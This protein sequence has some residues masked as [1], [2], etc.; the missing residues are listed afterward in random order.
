MG[1]ASSTLIRNKANPALVWPCYIGIFAPMAIYAA[2]DVIDS[3]WRRRKPS[4]RWFAIYL[5]SNVVYITAYV[6]Y[7][8][9]QLKEDTTVDPPALR[10]HTEAGTATVAFLV[11]LLTVRKIVRGFMVFNMLSVVA[12]RFGLVRPD[13][14]S[15][16]TLR[17]G[18]CCAAQQ[19]VHVPA[20]RWRYEHIGRLVEKNSSVLMDDDFP[21]DSARLA[22]LRLVGS[23]AV[24]G[25]SRSRACRVC[26]WLWQACCPAVRPRAHRGVC[27]RLWAPLLCIWDC[28]GCFCC[29]CFCCRSWSSRRRAP[30]HLQRPERSFQDTN[31]LQ[32]D[33]DL[34]IMT[35]VWLWRILS[36]VPVPFP[37][38]DHLWPLTDALDR[39]TLLAYLHVRG[40]RLEELDTRYGCSDVGAFGLR[41]G[42][43][44]DPAAFRLSSGFEDGTAC[45][46]EIHG[47]YAHTLKAVN[48]A[49]VLCLA[50]RQLQSRTVNCS[51]KFVDGREP[52]GVD[53][54][55][56]LHDAAF[57]E[58]P[59]VAAFRRSAATNLLVRFM[60]SAVKRAFRVRSCAGAASVYVSKQPSPAELTAAVLEDANAPFEEVDP[61]ERS[62]ISRMH[63]GVH[64]PLLSSWQ[65]WHLQMMQQA[66]ALPLSE[67][68]LKTDVIAAADYFRTVQPAG[69]LQP[70]PT[71][72][73][74]HPPL[75]TAWSTSTISCIVAAATATKPEQN[76]K[77]AKM[78]ALQFHHVV[79]TARLALT[80]ITDLHR[81]LLR[82]SLPH[83]MLDAVLEAG[84]A[85]TGHLLA[86]VVATSVRN[87]GA[88]PVT[89]A[90]IHAVN[91]ASSHVVEMQRPGPGVINR[92]GRAAGPHSAP[93]P[94][95]G[96]GDNLKYSSCVDHE[97][98]VEGGAKQRAEEVAE[99]A[100]PLPLVQACAALV[101]VSG[102]FVMYAHRRHSL[103]AEI[104]DGQ[105]KGLEEGGSWDAWLASQPEDRLTPAGRAAVRSLLAFFR[106]VPQR[107]LE[108]CAVFYPDDHEANRDGQ[109]DADR[110]FQR[111]LERAELAEHDLE[112]ISVMMAATFA[113]VVSNGHAFSNGTTELLATSPTLAN[114]PSSPAGGPPTSAQPPSA[115]ACPAST[116]VQRHNGL[117]LSALH[118]AVC[119]AWE[120]IMWRLK[121]DPRV[122]WSPQ[123][124][125][126]T[127]P[128]AAV[129][130][131]GVL[132]PVAAHAAVESARALA[133]ARS[134][135]VRLNQMAPVPAAALL[136]AH[137]QPGSREAGEDS[138]SDSESG[139]FCIVP[140]DAASGPTAVG[141]PADVIA[142]SATSAFQA[143]GSHLPARLSLSRSTHSS[144]STPNRSR[145]PFE[146]FFD[147]ANRV[148][149]FGPGAAA[150]T[151]PPPHS[152]A[153]AAHAAAGTVARSAFDYAVPSADV[154]VAFG[155]LS[156]EFIDGLMRTADTARRAAA[157]VAR[158]AQAVEVAIGAIHRAQQAAAVQEWRV[159]GGPAAVAD[160]GKHGAAEPRAQ[161]D[162]LADAAHAAL[163]LLQIAMFHV[164]LAEAGSPNPGAW[165]VGD[166]AEEHMRA[167]AARQWRLLR[168]AYA[169]WKER[170]R[171]QPPEPLARAE[172]LAE[173]AMLSVDAAGQR[174]PGMHGQP[175]PPRCREECLQHVHGV[176]QQLHMLWVELADTEPGFTSEA[177]R[178]VFVLWRELRAAL[179]ATAHPLLEHQPHVPAP[180]TVVAAWAQGA[181]AAS[182]W[183]E[184][185]GEDACMG[186][187]TRDRRR[188]AFDRCIFAGWLATE[189]HARAALHSEPKALTAGAH[190]HRVEVQ[191]SNDV[192][193]ASAAEEQEA[194]ADAAR[195]Y[196]AEL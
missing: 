151:H 101:A 41:P 29:G 1:S 19:R 3:R 79:G 21:G 108:S 187:K 100:L 42:E 130:T 20:A 166:V 164:V 7:V 120:Y 44:Y 153:H 132:R 84:S 62:M 11:N 2:H 37:E 143:F 69:P 180:E 53:R 128:A 147:E 6:V 10:N 126:E 172:R 133:A 118:H 116:S 99:E 32:D 135:W 8:Y 72:T 105:D 152:T 193:L 55:E 66:G 68:K 73:A 150:A 162:T 174:M 140:G 14:S 95:H 71:A 106:T 111:F 77:I 50:P 49:L 129:R 196:F 190:A 30:A 127:L 90:N 175:M 161:M 13:R 192:R 15:C 83:S 131:W 149:L 121:R 183:A 145:K 114:A 159:P 123:H 63:D 144:A 38:C 52:N 146:A 182:A 185:C 57:R 89:E 12:Q 134:A 26:H 51:S 58:G 98:G 113:A 171:Q 88:G 125:A 170:K 70:L 34:T 124:V 94:M 31:V 141:A 117:V 40:H 109:S 45:F 87:A 75:I 5:I 4:M 179:G 191:G 82:A 74:R 36:Q 173:A 178:H 169:A 39:A 78:P 136:Q 194:A 80:G 138:T 177:G 110:S 16:C 35:T 24:R 97:G 184:A 56:L 96:P 86:P 181:V 85:D 137:T 47:A 122:L 107:M 54:L 25:V 65:V 17:C 27:C 46:D 18:C 195:A 188:D 119:T 102:S 64:V 23:M 60:C 112:G 43:D 92:C 48:A 168:G 163:A 176:L 81:Q 104:A 61:A 22:W 59:I 33:T 28:C 186:H 160:S 9:A 76:E 103:R 167:F 148:F 165:S 139:S 142:T 67:H 154:L 91:G 155:S 157:R 158:S 156:P 93:G 189:M 115:H